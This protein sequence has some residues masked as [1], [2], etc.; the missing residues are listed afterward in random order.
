MENTDDIY[1]CCRWCRH[2]KI[3]NNEN[4]CTILE[5]EITVYEYNDWADCLLDEMI[6]IKHPES[7]CCKHFE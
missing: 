6:R 4:Y 3:M 1:H 2:F 5:G 7:F